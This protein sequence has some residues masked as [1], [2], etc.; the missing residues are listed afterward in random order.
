MKAEAQVLSRLPTDKLLTSRQG[1]PRK[2]VS[3]RDAPPGRLYE[4]AEIGK[5]SKLR[6]RGRTARRPWL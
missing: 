5:R 3:S 4:V 1:F 2:A 6:R